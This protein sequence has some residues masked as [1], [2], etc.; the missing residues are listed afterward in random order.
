MDHNETRHG[1]RPQPRPHCVRWRPSSPKGAQP[2]PPIFGPCLLFC[3]GPTAG[4]IKM[5]PGTEVELGPGHIVIDGDSAPPPRKGHSGTLFSA[6]VYIVAK[7]SPIS[8]TA[9]HLL[10]ELRD[11]I[12]VGYYSV[13]VINSV[14][15]TCVSESAGCS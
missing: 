7:W 2:Q 8:T 4:W 9:E 1:G 3:C 13:A 15:A 14:V 12:I 5:P 11:K 10:N 6:I